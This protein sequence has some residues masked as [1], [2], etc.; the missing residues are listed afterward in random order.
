MPETV[1]I[2][3]GKLAYLEERARTLAQ[4]KS[5][6]QLVMR[7]I[8]RVSTASGLED[9]VDCIMGNILDVIG[10]VNIILYYWIDGDIFSADVYGTKA[11]LDAINDELVLKVQTSREPIEV[12]HDFSDTRLTTPEFTNAYTWVYPL[13]VGNDLIGVLKME[14]LHIGMRTLYEQLPTFFNY[15]ALV[16]KNE[17]LGHTKLKQAYAQLSEMNEELEQE[18][19]ERE[20]AEEELPGP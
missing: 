16:L 3:E 12:E 13:L 7:L 5:Y 1:T 19:G 4:E 15:T 17:I 8:N 11:K 20:Q 6:L 2:P 18:I 9:T 14:S 10:G